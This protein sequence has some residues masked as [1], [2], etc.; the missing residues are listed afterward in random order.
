MREEYFPDKT[1]EQAE[2]IE[3]CMNRGGGVE[4]EQ[5]YFCFQ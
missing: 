5:S 1:R 2:P 3:S 4:P